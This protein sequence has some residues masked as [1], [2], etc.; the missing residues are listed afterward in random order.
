MA[1]T[2]VSSIAVQL[3]AIG[4][5][6]VR[7]ALRQLEGDATRSSGSVQNNYG[8]AARNLAVVGNTAARAG[9]I[10]GSGMAKILTIGG[11]MAFMFGPHGAI[12]GA[13]AVTGLAIWNH[14]DR[15]GKKLEE[16]AKKA[17][18]EMASL[19]K[20]SAETLA[21]R[22]NELVRGDP[23][24]EDPLATEWKATLEQR[25]TAL[26]TKRDGLKPGTANAPLF[27]YPKMKKDIQD[28]ID[29]LTN[30]I[31][32][33]E[34]LLARLRVL[35]E[36]RGQLE[37]EEVMREGKKG[38]ADKAKSDAEKVQDAFDKQIDTLADGVSM[39]IRR[40]ESLEDLRGLEVSLTK[41][42]NDST[43]SIE[44]QVR[45]ALRLDKVQKAL[46]QTFYVPIKNA[47]EAV[48]I[49]P[50]GDTA[51]DARQAAFGGPMATVK[52]AAHDDQLRQ[53]SVEAQMRFGQEFAA[54][55]E[56][57]NSTVRTGFATT[58]GDAI[59]QGFRAGFSGKGIGGVIKSFGKTVLSGVGGIFTQLGQTYLMYGSIM[60][61]LAALLPN[62][63]TA[64][65]AGLAIGA[66]LVAMGAALGAVAEGGGG[67]RGAP[68]PGS[69]NPRVDD[70]TRIRLTATSVADQ[71]RYEAKAP[72]HFTIIGP[73][74][75]AAFRQI[76]QGL[77]LHDRR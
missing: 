12:I 60:Q 9:S 64:G 73:N 20:A 50:S 18:A 8:R 1:R 4:L 5:D 17:R 27:R 39:N 29:L 10:G 24:A 54:V 52:T 46:A 69:F 45:A 38:W 44:A 75:A 34:D 74:D 41:A 14:F 55:Q 59:Y 33:R 30:E 58:L 47:G 49:T 32:R 16:T 28:E 57:I 66:A 21:E 36:K 7:S 71:A 53:A 76:R 15:I 63:F 77:D 72:V 56:S 65:Y 13:F 62:P 42:T 40:A 26:E 70:V 11:D 61:S 51:R 68:S 3:E 43:A 2:N 35:I 67:G 31:D 37:A 19:R 22:I 48:G 6:K 23:G 25:R